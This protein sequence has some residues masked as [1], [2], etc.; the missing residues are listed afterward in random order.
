VGAEVRKTK[1]GAEAFIFG[2]DRFWWLPLTR[3]DF[4]PSTQATHATDL[5]EVSY[6]DVLAGDLNNDGKAELVCVDPNKNLIEI[7]GSGS[8]GHWESLMHFKVFETDQ[9][10][11]GR[12]GSVLEP[13]ESIIAD[14][15]GDGKKDLILLVH[16]RVL[17]YPQE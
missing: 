15:T 4:T 7:L 10:Y 2:R 9:H 5:P 1:T 11:Q 3:D 14:V 17:V 6:S 12:K 8:D 16:D 13:R